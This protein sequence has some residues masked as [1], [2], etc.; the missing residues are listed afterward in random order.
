MK[1]FV[2][3]NAYYSI[4]TGEELCSHLIC[5]T[6]TNSLKNCPAIL[7]LPVHISTIHYNATVV[8]NIPVTLSVKFP[9]ASCPPVAVT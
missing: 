3:Y 8:Q 2:S 4:V 7:L 5:F 9:V 6:A 1:V